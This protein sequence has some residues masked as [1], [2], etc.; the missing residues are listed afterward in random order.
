MLKV[1]DNLQESGHGWPEA[2]AEADRG[3]KGRSLLKIGRDHCRQEAK[4]VFEHL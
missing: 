3:P 1:N 2:E 4:L